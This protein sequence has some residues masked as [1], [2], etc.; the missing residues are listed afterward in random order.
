MKYL[1]A[2]LISAAA[3]FAPIEASL[4]AMVVLT[5]SDMITGVLAARKQSLPITSSGLRRTVSKIF[6]YE[7]AVLMAYMAEKYLLSNVIP[8][9]KLCTGLITLV[10]LKSL[11]ENLD[12]IYGQP[13][14]K[15]LIDKLGSKNG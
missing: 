12:I 10:E 13:L 5:L 11:F 9:S 3:V 14:F 6:V 8:L 1:E 4:I 7:L 15:T 2:L